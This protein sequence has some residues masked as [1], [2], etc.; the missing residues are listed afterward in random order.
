MAGRSRGFHRLPT[1]RI[2]IGQ[3]LQ[4]AVLQLAAFVPINQPAHDE[5][6][7]PD[8]V[9]PVLR[10]PAARTGSVGI[11]H[12]LAFRAGRKQWLSGVHGGTWEMRT[13]TR[14]CIVA[15]FYPTQSA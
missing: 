2:L 14:S 11:E 3:Y 15:R 12:C 4:L 6:G 10:R 9:G 1:I 8:L 13:C 5:I 7:R